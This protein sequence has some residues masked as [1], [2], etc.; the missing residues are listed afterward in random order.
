M[1]IAPTHGKELFGW[2]EIG[3]KRLNVMQPTLPGN[4]LEHRGVLCNRFVKVSSR[5]RSGVDGDALSPILSIVAA[6]LRRS[7]KSPLR[8]RFGVSAVT[9]NCASGSEKKCL[10]VVQYL[11]R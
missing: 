9:R 1:P 3:R 7:E 11:R 4:A 10:G 2:H 8:L 5:D 6:T